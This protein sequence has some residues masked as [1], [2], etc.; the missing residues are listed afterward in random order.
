MAI[1]A[2]DVPFAIWGCSEIEEG[3][4]CPWLLATNDWS[5]HRR[6]ILAVTPKCVAAFHSFYPKLTN[7]VDTRHTNSIRWLRWAGFDIHP[8]E[9]F[10]LFGMPFHKFSKVQT[11]AYPSQRSA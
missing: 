2:D 10:G 9:P 4:G 5:K 1:C 11:C 7:Y 3:H 8:A 6:Y